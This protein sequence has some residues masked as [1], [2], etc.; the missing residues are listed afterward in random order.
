MT[1]I[2]SWQD[3]DPTEA[4]EHVE[5]GSAN[6]HEDPLVQIELQ[7]CPNPVPRMM[8]AR[9]KLA[10]EKL[11]LPF[12]NGYDHFVFDRYI[13]RSGQ[14]VPVYTWVDRTRIAE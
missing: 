3:V 14:L 1:E 2:T 4:E 13:T 9:S 8:V 6:H 7:G 10:D 5:Q 11:K 12:G